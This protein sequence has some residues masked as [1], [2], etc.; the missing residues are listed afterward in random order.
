[1]ASSF[2]PTKSAT[3]P[4]CRRQVGNAGIMAG[5]PGRRKRAS[6]PVSRRV[7]GS[8]SLLM[9]V[10]EAFRPSAPSTAFPSPPDHE[11]VD[12]FSRIRCSNNSAHSSPASSIFFAA[13]ARNARRAAPARRRGFQ[14]FFTVTRAWHRVKNRQPFQGSECLA[15][16]GSPFRPGAGPA[17]RLGGCATRSRC[18]EYG[19]V[20]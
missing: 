19:R 18:S 1:M 17:M 16:A 7:G 4:D 14:P 11:Q 15:R 13:A 10:E 3:Q 2:R 12:A 6:P 5:E 9:R 20:V 8:A